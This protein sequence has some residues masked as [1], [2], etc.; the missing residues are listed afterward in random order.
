MILRTWTGRIRAGRIR[1]ADGA[2]YAAYVETNGGA[3]YLATPGDLG[4]Q[5]V[6]RDLGDGTCEVATLSWRSGMDAV[7]GFG[8][9]EHVRRHEVVSGS[10]PS[11]APLR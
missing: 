8:H 10:G 6:F 5:T 3:T 7:H 4:W 2:E 11:S 9:P 1:T